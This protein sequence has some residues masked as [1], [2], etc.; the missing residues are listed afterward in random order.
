MQFIVDGLSD[1]PLY[2]EGGSL[3]GVLEAPLAGL[4]ERDPLADVGTG[5]L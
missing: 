5:P 1:G 2:G 4:L 3:A